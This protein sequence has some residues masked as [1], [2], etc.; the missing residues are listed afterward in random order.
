MG[1]ISRAQKQI[2]RGAVAVN[3]KGVW[4]VSAIIDRE[5]LLRGQQQRSGTPFRRDPKSREWIV[6]QSEGD[7]PPSGGVSRRYA[8]QLFRLC[9]GEFWDAHLLGFG[10]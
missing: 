2:A 3:P 10:E 7:V 6:R 4:L 8:G 9:C 1:V 5:L